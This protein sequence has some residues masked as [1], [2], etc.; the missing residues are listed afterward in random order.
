LASLTVWRP[1]LILRRRSAKE[2]AGNPDNP[3]A[4]QSD[5]EASGGA[6]SDECPFGRAANLASTRPRKPADED[7]GPHKW[8]GGEA[9]PKAGGMRR[10][11]R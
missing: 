4:R 11:R 9:R 7:M 10:S 1:G 5:I 3:L 8:G 6:Y 2:A